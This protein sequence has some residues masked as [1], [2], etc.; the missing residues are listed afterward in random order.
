VAFLPHAWLLR[1][2]WSDKLLD[3]VINACA[4]IAAYLLTAATIIPALD[5]RIAMK[6]L[7]AWGH[8]SFLIDYLRNAIYGCGLLLG[9][10]CASGLFIQL[11]HRFSEMDEVFSVAWWALLVY[12]VL[13]TVRATNLIISLL[14]SS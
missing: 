14:R 2:E 3:R 6:W 12:A 9:L 5:S 4:I 11:L 13:A 7:A 1:A 10:S 8:R